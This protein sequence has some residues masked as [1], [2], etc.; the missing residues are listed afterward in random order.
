MRGDDKRGLATRAGHVVGILWYGKPA[1]LIDPEKAAVDRPL[2]GL[3][4]R[5]DGAHELDETFREDP[6]ISLARS[7]DDIIYGNEGRDVLKGKAGNDHIEGEKERIEYMVI[8]E[9]MY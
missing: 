7:G 5:G 9:T 3:P 8:E 1:V 6:S 4:G 2:I